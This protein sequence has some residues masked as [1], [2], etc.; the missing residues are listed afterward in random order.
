MDKLIIE[1]RINEYMMREQGNLNVPYTVEEIVAEASAVRAA[2]AAIVHFHARTPDGQPDHTTETYARTVTAIRRSSDIL[3][4]PTLGDVTRDAPAEERL[5]HILAMAK[6]RATAPHMAPA[7]MG[8]LNLDIFNAQARRFETR[9]RI[10]KNSTATLTY[11][12]EN[13]R[14]AGVKPY[15]T[16]WNIGFTRYAA[17]FLDLGIVDEPAF[18][19][20]VLTDNSFLGGHPGTLK[21]LQAHLDFLPQTKRANWTV[22]NY[23][24]NLLPLAGAVIALGGHLSIGLGDYTYPELEHPTNAVLIRRVVALAK[25]VGREVATPEEAKRI[26]GIG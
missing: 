10:Y 4:H 1:A 23:G 15:M 2:G 26:M 5:A 24:G 8:S 19:G 14:K 21:G 17:A 9:E 22:M 3:V 16:C 6:D 25:D 7:D 18:L 20:L 11:L 13:M 12:C